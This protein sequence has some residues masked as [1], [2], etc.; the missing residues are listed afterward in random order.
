M[1]NEGLKPLWYEG[2]SKPINLE[3][4]SEASHNEDSDDELDIATY[5]ESDV[6]SG[7]DD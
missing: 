7:S 1:T 4:I 2:E 3:D 5:M 6:D